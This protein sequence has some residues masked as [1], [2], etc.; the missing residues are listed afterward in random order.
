MKVIEDLTVW[1][2]VIMS[3]LIFLNH[4][5]NVRFRRIDAEIR[6]RLRKESIWVSFTTTKIPVLLK[7]TLFKDPWVL[8]GSVIVLLFITLI[9]FSLMIMYGNTSQIL[10][11]WVFHTMM[12][13]AQVVSW[14]RYYDSLYEPK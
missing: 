3:I 8:L 7:E 4:I 2:L 10:V 12:R 11:W 9:Q 14:V 13:I 6:P 5:R 1:A